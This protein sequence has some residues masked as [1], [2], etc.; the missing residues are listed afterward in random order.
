MVKKVVSDNLHSNISHGQGTWHL[1]AVMISSVKWN[2]LYIP[3]RM[4]IK[5]N[6]M[7]Y[8]SCL[9]IPYCRGNI[10]VCMCKHRQQIATMVGSPFCA[11]KRGLMQKSINLLALHNLRSSGLICMF[12]TSS[13]FHLLS[14]ISISTPLVL[15]SPT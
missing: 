3:H 13:L 1:W 4:V 8:M 14:N 5:S 11:K 12:S 7:P 9:Y 6:E 10:F 15:L 2:W